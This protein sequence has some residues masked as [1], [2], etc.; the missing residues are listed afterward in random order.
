MI[1]I[2]MALISLI[3][4]SADALASSTVELR[5]AV[6]VADDAPLLL[7]DIAE[8]SGSEALRLAAVVVK[9]DPAAAVHPGGR[10]FEITTAEVRGLLDGAGARWGELALSGSVCRV[11]P[12]DFEALEPQAVA[13]APVPQS[14]PGESWRA[15][16]TAGTLLGDVGRQI[17]A[18]LGISADRLRVFTDS[19][20]RALLATRTAGRTVQIRPTG[21]GERIP[22]AI[23]VF[24][25]GATIVEG[26]VRVGVRVLKEVPIAAGDI[27]RGAAVRPEDISVRSE[28]VTP[29]DSLGT[30]TQIVG[31]ETSRRVRAGEVLG[32]SMLVSPLAIEKG[33]R[34]SVRCVTR[35]IVVTSQAHALEDGRLGDEI[36]LRPLGADRR[37]PGFSARVEGPGKAIVFTDG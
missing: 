8:L 23:S 16:E 21:M 31:A 20:D 34:V 24:E 6:R 18:I 37:A 13:P 26:N 5:T 10:S 27:R 12:I 17:A 32:P 7:E 3:L 11:M 4:G 30:A 29:D 1:R 35:G 2:L 14:A 25:D 33:D 22:L 28:W 36:M 19:R 9:E 15:P